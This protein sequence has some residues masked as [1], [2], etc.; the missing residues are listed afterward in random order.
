M[1]YVVIVNIIMMEY[2]T[3]LHQLKE[4]LVF[5]ET[6]ILLLRLMSQLVFA[7]PSMF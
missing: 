1:L 5:G 4:V 2:K 6:V 7:V 3:S